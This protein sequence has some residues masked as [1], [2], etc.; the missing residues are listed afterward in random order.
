M[1]EVREVK[2]TK[3]DTFA[4]FVKMMIAKDKKLKTHFVPKGLNTNSKKKD[5][6]NF[7]NLME[8]RFNLMDM[9]VAQAKQNKFLSNLQRQR[10]EELSTLPKST[11]VSDR[12]KNILTSILSPKQQTPKLQ[13]IV[14]LQREVEIQYKQK[15]GAVSDKIYNKTETKNVVVMAHSKQQA[16]ETARHEYDEWLHNNGEDSEKTVG[17]LSQNIRI[18]SAEDVL[19]TA[20]NE[21]TQYMRAGS[22]ILAKEWLQYAKGVS[23]K[24]FEET[25]NQCCYHQLSYILNNAPVG[26]NQEFIGHRGRKQRTNPE[27]IFQL[28][29]N[30]VND[31]P[32][33]YPNFNMKSGVTTDMVI[34]LCETLGRS[35]Y[36]YNGDNKCFAKYIKPNSNYCP[37]AFYKY[38]G[39]MFLIDDKTYFKNIAESNKPNIKIITSLVEREVKENLDT[40]LQTEYIE[41]FDVSQAKQIESKLYI[42]NKSHIF[43]EYK[44]YILTYKTEPKV[45]CKEG[46]VVYM[47]YHNEN[48]ERVVINCDTN[49]GKCAMDKV[50]YE[51]LQTECLKNDIKYTNQGI[52]TIVNQLLD[53]YNGVEKREYLSKEHKKIIKQKS[54]GLCANCQL[55]SKIYEYDHIKPL[56]SGGTNDLENFQILCPSCHQ[57]KTTK[58]QQD[59]SQN[60]VSKIHS[61]FNNI[62]LEKVINTTHFKTHQ[63]VEKIV[64][65]QGN[66][67]LP[68]YKIDMRR[69][70]KNNLYYSKYEFPVYSVMDFPKAFSG[71]VKC[72]YYYV[73]SESKF[74][75]R[76]CGWYCEALVHHCLL[77][78]IITVED[79][80]YEFIPSNKL[81]ANYFCERI[82]FIIDSFEDKQLQKLAINALIGCWGIQ[83]KISSHTKFSLAEDEA[84]QWFVENNNIFINSHDLGD[85]ITLFEGCYENQIAV[86]DNAYP[87]YSMILQME[88]IE[89]HKLELWIHHNKG[90]PLERNTDAILYQRET[91]IDMTGYCWDDE[92]KTPKYQNESATYLKHESKPQFTRKNYLRNEN[93]FNLGWKLHDLTPRQVFDLKLCM[94]INGRAGT[95]K[96]WYLNQLINFIKESGLKYECLAP[97]NKSAR[98]INGIT[99]DSLNFRSVFNSGSIVN[100]AKSIH[101]L[102]VDEISMVPEK[103]YRLLTNIKK[104]NPKI[105]FYICGD[106]SQL[107]PVNDS[108]SG[109]YE[110]SPVLKDLCLSNKLVLTACKRSDDVLFNLCKNTQ[111]LDVEQFPIKVETNLNIAFTHETRKRINHECMMRNI[112]TTDTPITILPDENNPKTQLLFLTIGMPIICHRTNKKM[113]ILNSDR[114]DITA[115]DE[116]EIQF[117]NEILREQ[118]KPDV[119]IS[120][121]DFNKFFYLAYCIT[122][123]ASQGETF[124]EQYTIYDWGRMCKRGKYVALSRGTKSENIQ[125]HTEKIERTYNEFKKYMSER[126][127]DTSDD[128]MRKMYQE[129]QLSRKSGINNLQQE[130]ERIE[131]ESEKIEREILEKEQIKQDYYNEMMIKGLVCQCGKIALRKK[132]RKDDENQGKIYYECRNMCGNKCEFIKWCHETE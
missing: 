83:K 23:Q 37:I 50:G 60:I 71:E 128:K 33:M 110:N 10:K 30:F 94:L 65:S 107:K 103:F 86:D 122:V 77:F 90:I 112:K 125:I 101:Y 111:S 87:L 48:D 106:F 56:S 18:Q 109:S 58:E 78:H 120:I 32:E 8:N 96:T 14:Q 20:R 84:S 36:A 93:E 98:L 74:P 113:E 59:G 64:E 38:N 131:L 119:K 52:G 15:D 27:G 22:I 5:L 26:R 53:R 7:F 129:F 79:I 43:E 88:A 114:F 39:H 55:S 6:A 31:K 35:C 44:E 130:D 66:D 67:E 51:R 46:R 121:N 81:P 75:L 40:L 124:K 42:L 97:T 1:S 49:Y 17:I 85:N 47:C 89:L 13:F 92:L 126:V 102:I 123:H 28:F 70:R 117:S 61:S 11:P 25:D 29:Q 115:I 127:I 99:L 63:F 100:W 45:R 19:N 76:G 2:R 116:K 105:I 57:E 68:V 34:Y 69:C 4:P 72:G 21:R 73:N 3:K 62:V 104:I 9:T 118:G 54:N 80:W 95:G 132:H 12:F 91:E 41:S 16:Q 82:D 24:A 108:W